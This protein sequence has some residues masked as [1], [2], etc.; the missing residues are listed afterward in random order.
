MGRILFPAIFA[1]AILAVAGTSSHA[2]IPNLTWQAAEM[3]DEDVAYP[4]SNAG[5]SVVSWQG[6]WWVVY[7]KYGDIYGR[8]RGIGGWNAPVRL[9]T[10]P[11]LQTAPHLDAT[12]TSL[13]VVWEDFR[14]GQPEVW[15]RRFNGSSWNQEE[16]LS[17]GGVAS[18]SP[19]IAASHDDAYAVWADSS[20]TGVRIWGRLF[21]AGSWQTAEA[22]SPATGVAREPSV[23]IQSFISRV[24]VAWADF[25]HGD[26]EI[27]LRKGLVGSSWDS[28]Q[29]MTDLPIA[30]RR[31]S[32]RSE[33]CCGDAMDDA[34]FI[35]FEGTVPGGTTETWVIDCYGGLV[36]RVSAD[37]GIPSVRP[38]AAAFAFSSS[39]CGW[40]G[41]QPFD[42]VTWS[43]E[44]APGGVEHRTVMRPYCSISA[45]EDLLPRI[46]LTH[47]VIGAI[48]GNPTAGLMQVWVEDA[49][50]MAALVSR[51]G[52]ILGC[53]SA[54]VTG[55]PAIIVAPAGVPSNLLHFEDTCNGS[56]FANRLL[57]L[58]FSPALD[59]AI[60]WD[61][62]QEHPRIERNTNA[63]GDATFALRGGG[64]FQAGSVVAMCEY[65]FY[66]EIGWAGVKSPDVDG[67]CAVRD[68]DVAYVESRLGTADFCA[69]L[70][71]SGLVGEAD[72]TIV[73]DALGQSCSD[74]MEVG[75]S[76]AGVFTDG[77]SV[78]PNPCRE[79]A[80]IEVQ[81]AGESGGAVE[82]L[83]GGGRLVRRLSASPL[84]VGV[85]EV[86]WDLRDDA[87]RPLAS[88]VYF[89]RAQ[90]HSGSLA[91]PIL[92]IR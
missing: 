53:S 55:P 50:G 89:V 9:T 3:V 16:C 75:E 71:G 12:N 73:R 54:Q 39:Y 41:P 82:I 43:D 44:V 68:N 58:D 22:I 10:D 37:D 2:E 63:Q 14:S 90:T 6:Q 88:G 36:E 42:F 33:E 27:Y 32:L 69:D 18:G 17:C 92:V 74:V 80:F 5:V 83:D 45:G 4:S 66:P 35:A 76:P 85:T 65:W 77:L 21:H 15:T 56:P 86:M 8:S 62:L 67:D 34:P 30:C 49:G 81:L 47:A 28:E 38:S 52:S 48:E 57:I 26:P 87:S 11:G 70:D 13:I 31:P 29:R 24:M 46:G 60:R 59:A 19:V 23:S 40:G 7:E 20:Q 25:R 78:H 91:R 64:C 1:F 79:A 72:L 61:P 51:R 84:P